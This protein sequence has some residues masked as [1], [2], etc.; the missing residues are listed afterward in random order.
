MLPVS[1]ESTSMPFLLMSILSGV[2]YFAIV[3]ATPLPSDRGDTVC[4]TPFPNV[5]SPTTVARLLSLR[6]PVMISLALAVLPLTSRK[7]GVLVSDPSFSVLKL[8]LAPALLTTD[9]SCLPASRNM[10]AASTPARKKP[11][12]LSRRSIT[13]HLTPCAACLST[14]A[15]TSSPVLVSNCLILIQPVEPLT[16]PVTGL[17]LTFCRWIVTSL[18]CPLSL[19][20]IDTSDPVGPRTS[21]AISSAV[22][23]PGSDL[24]LLTSLKSD[25]RFRP[26]FSAGPPS[27]TS[28]I[29]TSFDSLSTARVTPMPLTSCPLPPCV[30]DLLSESYFCG[31]MKRVYWSPRG[32]SISSAMALCA[33]SDDAYLR[34][35]RFCRMSN[36]FWLLKVLST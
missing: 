4:T 30:M 29:L 33:S 14:S 2:R 16:P 10:L 27:A 32:L 9:T 7:R 21:A 1:A 5:L 11:P 26:A 6:A 15:C 34:L 24:T 18:S 20:T 35:T 23:W 12:A 19:K 36:Q 22:T 17:M 8:S 25:P 28:T 13:R 3:T 31:L